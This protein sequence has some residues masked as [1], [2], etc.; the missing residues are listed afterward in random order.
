[1][2]T[3]K[4]VDLIIILVLEIFSLFSR[5]ALK[6]MFHPRKETKEPPIWK[7]PLLNCNYNK[8]IIVSS[9]VKLK[10]LIE[11]R[12]AKSDIFTEHHKKFIYWNCHPLTSQS[13]FI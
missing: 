7:I 4:S 13:S 9:K 5:V 6:K 1:M 12:H 3:S 2:L 10:K 11:F 8:C